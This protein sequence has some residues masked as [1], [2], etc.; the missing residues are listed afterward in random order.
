MMDNSFRVF[1]RQFCGAMVV[2]MIFL[3]LNQCTP[4][5]P[6]TQDT[7]HFAVNSAHL[8]ALYEEKKVADQDVGIIHIYSEYPDYH[9]VGDNDEGIACVDDAS[10][11]AV[12]YL[13]QYK[14]YSSKEDLHKA[15]ML[16][17]FLM[18]MQ[19]ENGYFYNFIWPDGSINKD[20]VTSAPSPV[21][22]SWR[23]LWA[24]GE[25]ID[26]L[27]PNKPL[28]KQIS[29]HRDLLINTMLNEKFLFSTKTDTAGGV[30]IPMWLPKEGATDQSSIILLGL[31]SAYQQNIY[32]NDTPKRYAINM[33]MNH[34]A[35]GIMMMQIEDPGNFCDGAFLSWQN[36]WHAYANLQSY[37]LLSAGQALK[38]P[39]MESHALYEIDNFYPAVYARGYLESFW[40]RMKKGRAIVYDMKS[41]PQIAYGIRPM[42]F[43][44][45]KAYEVTGDNKYK[46]RASQLASWFSGQNPA[47]AAMYDPMTGVGFDGLSG[48]AQINRNSGA[49]STIEALL[50]MQ[51]LE[52]MK[53]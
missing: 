29:I 44:C 30:M 8:D 21:W 22:W 36:L 17:R 51:V 15:T 5:V 50:T 11:A 48:P 3:S 18:V 49:E 32:K 7:S 2:A 10:R 9:W 42:V 27:G 13:R 46:T 33:M 53:K 34:L 4:A 45:M 23:S 1:M 12:F 16:L 43:A 37:A 35:D 39:H 25:A 41:V 52:G 6:K 28:S 40:I 31:A 14:K 19:A 20:G 24:F 26:V 47:H 38:D